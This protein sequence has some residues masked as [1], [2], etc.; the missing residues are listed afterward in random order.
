MKKL[1]LI[2]TA[3]CFLAGPV[4]ARGEDDNYGPANRQSMQPCSGKWTR[5][6]LCVVPDKK[7]YRVVKDKPE[8]AKKC[9]KGLFWDKG[10]KKCVE[11]YDNVEN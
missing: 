6:G 9:S 1:L 7:G 3:L 8:Q 10:M 2:T 11:P 5:D 4:Y